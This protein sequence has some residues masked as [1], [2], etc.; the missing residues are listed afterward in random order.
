MDKKHIAVIGATGQIGTPL[1]KGLLLLGH[2][3]TI[4]T[5]ARSAKNDTKLAEFEKQGAK[6][7]EC[8][9]MHDVDSMANILQGIDTLV[10]SVPGSKEIIQKSE[11]IWLEAA[12]KAGVERFVPTEFG[13]HT[14][15]IEMGDGEIFDQKKRFHDLLMNSGIGWTLYYNGGIFDYF[16]PNLRFFRKITTFGNL[17]LPIHTHDIEDI[18]YIA[19][20]VVTD[21]RTLNKCVQVDYNVLTQNEM[22][23]QIKQNWPDY[24]FE[25]EHFSS[26]YI[27]EMKE[28]AGDEITSKK[29]AETDKE[30]WGINYVNYVIGKLAA[31]TDLTLRASELYPAYVCKRPEEALSDAKFV[32]ED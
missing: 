20:M 29:G 13:S 7:V 18:G 30:R 23:A 12:V 32:F 10:A 22:L 21:E 8:A 24:P 15:A 17:E 19:A 3:V 1:S 14:Q 11:P 6:I 28:N 9:D 4:I 5:R 26:E 27:T 2:D 25:Y 31:F 16:L